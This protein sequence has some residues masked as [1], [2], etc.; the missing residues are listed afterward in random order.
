VWFNAARV[1]ARGEV[2]MRRKERKRAVAPIIR[3]PNRSAGRRHVL[4]IE[5][6]HGQ[7][8]DVGDTERLQVRD[9]VDEPAKGA[10]MLHARRRMARETVDVQLVDH[11]LAKRPVEW[12]VA[13]PVVVVDG[14]D[15]RPHGRLDAARARVLA[16]P[17]GI[18]HESRPRI[19]QL[20][21]RIEA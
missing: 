3:E 2:R 17:R 13:C 8:L 10:G 9:L 15:L 6:E 16:L 4:P 1:G 21:L 11:G 7:E 14:N 18:A 5:R 12:R 19:E 20:T